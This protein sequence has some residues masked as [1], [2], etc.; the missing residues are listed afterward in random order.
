MKMPVFVA[1]VTGLL[2]PASAFADG[3]HSKEEMK[4]LNDSAAALSGIDA[5]LSARVKEM[6]S[7]EKREKKGLEKSAEARAAYVQSLRD[8]AAALR[9]TRADLAERLEKFAEKKERGH[10]KA[11]TRQ[12]ETPG[13]TGARPY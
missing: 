9:A 11:G 7:H 3:K 2:F 6:A 4:L 10:E 13:R 5:D 1:L 8:A 12:E